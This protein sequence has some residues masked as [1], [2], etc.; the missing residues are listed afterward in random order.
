MGKDLIWD[1]YGLLVDMRVF[2]I[3]GFGRY[4]IIFMMWN[5]N[6]I[7]IVVGFVIFFLIIIY[8]NW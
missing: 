1:V 3:V 8:V 5:K 7:V 4:F 2:L 6:F